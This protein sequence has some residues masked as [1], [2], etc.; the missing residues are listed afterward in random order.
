MSGQVAVN[1]RVPQVIVYAVEHTIEFHTVNLQRSFQAETLAGAARLP[2]MLRRN[3][4]N[5][6]RIDNAALHQVHCTWIEVVAHAVIVHEVV[7]AV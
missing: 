4:R 2:R 7:W 3:G 6:I 5:E 1:L